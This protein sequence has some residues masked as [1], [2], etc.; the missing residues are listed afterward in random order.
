M[1]EDKRKAKYDF[2]ETQPVLQFNGEATKVRTQAHH[3]QEV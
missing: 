1:A 2:W 3:P